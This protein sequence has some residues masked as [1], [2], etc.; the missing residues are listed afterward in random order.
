[1]GIIKCVLYLQ[2]AAVWN[3]TMKLLVL[4]LTVA[5]LFTAGESVTY[6]P[7]DKHNRLVLWGK[8]ICFGPANNNEMFLFNRHRSNIWDVKSYKEIKLCVCSYFEN[9]SKNTTMLTEVCSSVLLILG[10]ALTCH[11]C[12]PKRAGENCELS[13]ETCKPGK[14]ACG[15]ASFLREP[16]EFPWSY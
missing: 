11:R 14:D 10:E 16:C 8:E 6:S 9:K 2:Q 15:A 4:A 5:L 12:V 13:M 7:P 3:E 1:M